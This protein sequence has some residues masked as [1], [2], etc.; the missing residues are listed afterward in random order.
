MRRRKPVAEE[1]PR[2][3]QKCGANSH[4][5][6]Y[7]L[8]MASPAESVADYGE[9]EP[10]LCL[11]C[12]KRLEASL[13]VLGSLRCLDCRDAQATLNPELV[14]LWQQRGSNF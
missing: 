12:G 13:S 3:I 1:R 6:A 2:P 9:Q 4:D 7:V 5:G 11:A 8:Y 10:A 14:A